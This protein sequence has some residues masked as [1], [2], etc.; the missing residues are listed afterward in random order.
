MCRCMHS[1]VHVDARE[2]YQVFL[3]HFLSN[4]FETETLIEP[5]TQ[6]AGQPPLML[7]Y[8]SPP[9]DSDRVEVHTIIPGFLHSI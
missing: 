6:V 3:C 9:P 7:L 8:L 4:C 2:G 5:R 1:H